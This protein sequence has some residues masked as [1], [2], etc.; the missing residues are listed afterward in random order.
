MWGMHL[1]FWV[2]FHK[3]VTLTLTPHSSLA[4]VW[5]VASAAAR[6][7]AHTDLQRGLASS[8][9]WTAS[10]TLRT[11]TVQNQHEPIHTRSVITVKAGCAEKV[12][13]SQV[14]A[15]SS[16]SW[17]S[18]HVDLLYSNYSENN[19]SQNDQRV[20]G[21][22]WVLAK[23]PVLTRIWGI[24]YFFSDSCCFTTGMLLS[25]LQPQQ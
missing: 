23:Q 18:V 16:S 14:V 20:S 13:C 10:T 8:F 15:H 12:G 1:H 5:K 4:F 22:G 19:G 11:L 17:L 24:F 3:N 2:A 25:R 7:S 21:T 9:I 6:P